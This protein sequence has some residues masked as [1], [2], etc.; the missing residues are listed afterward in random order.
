M[1]NIAHAKEALELA[2]MQEH[3]EQIKHQEEIRV[4][5]LVTCI[6][7]SFRVGWPLQ[8][9]FLKLLV[10]TLSPFSLTVGIVLRLN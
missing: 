6:Y 3:T 9:R 2:K 7:H 1:Y 10:E 4:T 5:S 8:A